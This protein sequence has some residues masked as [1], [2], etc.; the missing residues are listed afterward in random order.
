MKARIMTTIPTGGWA[1]SMP[2]GLWRQMFNAIENNGT[3]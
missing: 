2:K 1:E 3:Y